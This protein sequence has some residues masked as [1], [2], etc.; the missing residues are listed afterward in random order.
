[1]LTVAPSAKHGEL[2]R[3]GD[4]RVAAVARSIMDKPQPLGFLPTWWFWRALYR[5]RR[6]RVLMVVLTLPAWILTLA[7]WTFIGDS[8]L[9]PVILVYL[10]EGLVEKFV[11]REILR[12]RMALLAD[13]D[14][15]S[16]LPSAGR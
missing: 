16:E 11:R 10:T 14:T 15:G 12:R 2:V 4:E 1:M 6:F 7:W 3:R 8:F 5:E 9:A 13:A